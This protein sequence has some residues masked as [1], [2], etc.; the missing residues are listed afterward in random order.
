MI[1]SELAIA[2]T[3]ET[4]LIANVYAPSGNSKR[5]ERE[6]FFNHVLPQTLSAAP[7]DIVLGGD[8]NC[9]LEAT[10]VTGHGCYSHALATLVHGYSLRDAWQ[11]P[12]GRHAYT[13]YTIHGVTRLDR[14][15]LSNDLLPRKTGITTVAAAFSDHHAVVLRLSWSTP[16]L[17]RGRGTW[18]YIE[19]F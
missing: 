13:H 11:A 10:D 3:F 17:R 16:V 2:A 15:Y 7:A 4:L 6:D 18:N 14:I 9:I 5:T 19:T 1:P 8:F 12:P